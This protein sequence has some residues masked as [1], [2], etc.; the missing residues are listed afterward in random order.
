MSE[1]IEDSMEGIAAVYKGGAVQPPEASQLAG[2]GGDLYFEESPQ[3]KARRMRR[4]STGGSTNR[5]ANSLKANVM[6]SRRPAD[7]DVQ[8]QH[9]EEINDHPPKASSTSARTALEEDAPVR[10][11]KKS[12]QLVEGG[13]SGCCGLETWH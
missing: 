10:K 12:T 9:S 11:P 7:Q 1:V 5:I 2:E 8:V 13:K 6:G 3:T 4:G